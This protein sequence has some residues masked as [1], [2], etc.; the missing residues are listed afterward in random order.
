MA[1]KVHKW[2]SLGLAQ[3]RS[4]RGSGGPRT[5]TKSQIRTLKFAASSYIIFCFSTNLF[6]LEDNHFTILWRF[7]PY[8]SM[9][10]PQVYM[11]P[12]HPRPPSPL[13]PNP[14]PL[15]LSQSTS[16][17]CPDSSIE[18]TLVIY[19]LYGNV[20]ASVLL[21]QIIPPSSSPTESKCVFHIC[22]SFAALRI[23]LPVPSF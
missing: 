21:S 1:R 9:N 5:T 8:I 16:F 15:G 6:W 22:V 2:R 12:L 20:Y 10:Q 19:F 14:I 13:P 7:L 11:C 4:L 18:L 23:G 17:G 3:G